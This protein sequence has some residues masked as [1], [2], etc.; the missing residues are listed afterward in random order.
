MKQTTKS[1]EMK[2]IIFYS[3]P[4]TFKAGHTYSQHTKKH[5]SASPAE[6]ASLTACYLEIKLVKLINQLALIIKIDRFFRMFVEFGQTSVHFEG[7]HKVAQIILKLVNPFIIRN[8]LFEL[9][10]VQWQISY[11]S[12]KNRPCCRNNQS[13]HHQL[14]QQKMH[15]TVHTPVQNLRMEKDLIS[16]AE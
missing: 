5:S 4:K 10:R 11:T 12:I 3:N 2:I 16:K 15:R 14:R 8:V 6:Y 1:G 9:M 7:L 13:G